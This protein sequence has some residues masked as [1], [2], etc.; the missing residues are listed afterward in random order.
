[1][2]HQNQ[3]LSS[4]KL[5]DTVYY[6]QAKKSLRSALQSFTA[7]LKLTQIGII[8]WTIMLDRR[9]TWTGVI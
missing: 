3:N 4:L 8:Q 1:M 5:L 9:W 6:S 7:D 2:T